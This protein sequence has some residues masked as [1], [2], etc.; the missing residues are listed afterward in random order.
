MNLHY[1]RSDAVHVT[2]GHRG[3]ALYICAHSPHART[4]PGRFSDLKPMESPARLAAIWGGPAGQK[5]ESSTLRSAISSHMHDRAILTRVHIYGCLLERRTTADTAGLPWQTAVAALHCGPGPSLQNCMRAQAL[6]TGI[7]L[8]HCIC[9]MDAP[10]DVPEPSLVAGPRWQHS[11]G[12]RN[13]AL[14]C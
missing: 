8:Q 11:G 7:T 13:K 12:L 3:C 6:R 2:P 10:C 5:V 14:Q 1:R 9:S 4:R